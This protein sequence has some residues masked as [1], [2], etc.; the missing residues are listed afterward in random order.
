VVNTEGGL[1]LHPQDIAKIGLL[2]LHNGSW[3]GEQIVSAD[4]VRRSLTPAIEVGNGR[5]YG[6]QWW[7]QAHGP[8][9]D[10]IWAAHGFGGQGMIVDAKRN[11]ILVITGWDIPRENNVT[12][13]EVLERVVDSAS[14]DSCAHVPPT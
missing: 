8:D 3:N 7:L 9:D 11:L 6:F 14:K 2:Y 12:Q 5:Q 1:Y 4:W 10:P 13:K